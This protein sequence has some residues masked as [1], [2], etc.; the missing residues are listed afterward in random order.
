MGIPEPQIAERAANRNPRASFF[1]QRFIRAVACGV[2]E[3]GVLP[4]DGAESG[5]MPHKAAVSDHQR[6]HRV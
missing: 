3:V 4:F 1:A 2:A 5:C 6:F